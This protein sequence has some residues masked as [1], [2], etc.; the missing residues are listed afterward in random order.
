MGIKV[1]HVPC[2]NAALDTHNLEGIREAFKAK[3]LVVADVQ[4][5]HYMWWYVLTGDA[6]LYLMDL[7]HGGGMGGFYLER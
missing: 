7:S 5:V 6:D 3:G 4:R 2:R 1:D